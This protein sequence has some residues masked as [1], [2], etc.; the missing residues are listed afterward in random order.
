MKYLSV[1]AGP[2]VSAIP[3]KSSLTRKGCYWDNPFYRTGTKGNRQASHIVLRKI[4]RPRKLVMGETCQTMASRKM[5]SLS[6][7]R[8][9]PEAESHRKV[10]RS[11]LHPCAPQP[12][13]GTSFKI[14]STWLLG[15]PHLGEAAACEKLRLGVFRLELE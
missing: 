14:T 5:A 2:R 11:T 10:I 6:T 7:T 8:P 12:E 15:R 13:E 9:W 4:K 1:K 3:V